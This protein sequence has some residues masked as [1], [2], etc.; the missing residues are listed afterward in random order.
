MDDDEQEIERLIQYNTALSKQVTMIYR[1]WK[2]LDD[3][4][5]AASG[6]AKMT[7]EQTADWLRKRLT[8]PAKQD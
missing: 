4:I 8:E 7:P 1:N 6:Y 3:I 2:A 5:F